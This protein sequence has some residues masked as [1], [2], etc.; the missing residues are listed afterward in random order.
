MGNSFALDEAENFNLGKN[1]Y[2]VE[3]LTFFMISERKSGLFFIELM[4]LRKCHSFFL[5]HIIF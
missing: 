1:Y 5:L 3:P 2:Y 4:I